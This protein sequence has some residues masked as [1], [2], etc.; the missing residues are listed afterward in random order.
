MLSDNSLQKMLSKITK[1]NAN[2]TFKTSND[3]AYFKP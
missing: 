1:F 2:I 3:K